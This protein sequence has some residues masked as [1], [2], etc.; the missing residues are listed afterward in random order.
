MRSR[1][2][3]KLVA[4]A[5]FDRIIYRCSDVVTNHTMQVDAILY[6]TIGWN[7]GLFIAFCEA[8][9]LVKTNRFFI[10]FPNQQLH[11]VITFFK[12]DIHAVV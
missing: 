2:K 4:N 12:G 6:F 3:R 1:Q 8:I 7:I 10:V 11:V 5:G 9:M